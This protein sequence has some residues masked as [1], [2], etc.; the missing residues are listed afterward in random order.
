MNDSRGELLRLLLLAEMLRAAAAG[1]T[2]EG[3]R[4][5]V[6]EERAG[7]IIFLEEEIADEE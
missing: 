4:L 5:S 1:I 3:F 2:G 7:R 6:G